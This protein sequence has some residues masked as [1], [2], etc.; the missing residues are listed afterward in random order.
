MGNVTKEYD[1]IRQ[2]EHRDKRIRDLENTLND[3]LNDCINFD[4]G[5]L[6]DVFMQQSSRVLKGGK[7]EQ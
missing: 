4:G 7:Y 2:L 6:T 3:Q 5:K 1:L